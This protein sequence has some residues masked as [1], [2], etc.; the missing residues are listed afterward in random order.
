MSPQLKKLIFK[1]AIFI[2]S[3]SFAWWVIKG[4][5]L[6][7]IIESIMPLRIVAEIVA[8]IL[9]TFFLTS[10]ISVAMLIVLARDNNPIITA[11]LAGFGAVLGDFLI[12]KFFKQEVSTDLNLVSKELHLQKINKLLQIFHL[13]FVTPFLGA[14]LIASPFPDELGLMMMGVSKLGYREI[15]I[16]TYILNTAGILLIVAPVNLLS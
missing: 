9:Y 11:I 7:S 2:L 6:H 4:G 15:A 13:D 10:P 14:V 5:Y 8:G 16:L 12:I 1:S 3:L